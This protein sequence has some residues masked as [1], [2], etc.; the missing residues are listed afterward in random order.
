M[1]WNHNVHGYMNNLLWIHWRPPVLYA[2]FLLILIFLS[3]YLQS[4]ITTAG[5]PGSK[6]DFI[7]LHTF[8]ILFVSGKPSLSYFEV[9]YLIFQMLVHRGSKNAAYRSHELW[10]AFA[11]RH[12]LSRSFSG[13]PSKAMIFS[14]NSML[15]PSN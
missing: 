15:H 1:S 10:E 12:T 5:Y 14:C 9:H 6:L 11:C 8:K 3:I 13:Q 2:T 7:W 4:V